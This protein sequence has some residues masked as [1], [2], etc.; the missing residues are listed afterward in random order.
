MKRVLS[1]LYAFMLLTLCLLHANAQD[2]KKIFFRAELL[3]YDEAIL[4]DVE[5][6]SGNV[7]FICPAA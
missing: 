6:Y 2:Q 5:R 4:P 1:F 7:I 3:E